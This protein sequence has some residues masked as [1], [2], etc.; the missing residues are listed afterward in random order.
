[1]YKENK[2]NNEE[3]KMNKEKEEWVPPKKS[4][5]TNSDPIIPEYYQKKIQF[6]NDGMEQE[7]IV[8][9]TDYLTIIKDDIRNLRKSNNYQLS[10]IKYDI[11]DASKNEIIDLFNT[12]IGVINELIINI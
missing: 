12:T 9:K 8:L 1:M 5:L 6:I 11:D 4:G 2:M 3:N 7:T 10:F